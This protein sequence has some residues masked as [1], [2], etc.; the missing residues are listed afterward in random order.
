MWVHIP[1]WT[2]LCTHVS[3]GMCVDMPKEARV[4]GS[5]WAALRGCWGPTQ[6]L[7][8]CIT[9]LT[10]ESSLQ[11]LILILL[12]TNFWKTVFINYMKMRVLILLFLT[13][14]VMGVYNGPT[15]D[16]ESYYTQF[17]SL[18]SRKQTV[19]QTLVSGKANAYLISVWLYIHCPLV[20]VSVF[21]SFLSKIPGNIA[22]N[23]WLNDGNP[24]KEKQA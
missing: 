12:R 9:C 2:R 6:V 3:V 16:L 1:K 14:L 21:F 4:T 5:L 7:C 19:F 10:A 18:L 17:H 24:L 13:G 22:I 15:S 23:D 20:S 8:K 11:L